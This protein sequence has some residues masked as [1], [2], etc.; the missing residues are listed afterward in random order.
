MI[1]TIQVETAEAVMSMKQGNEEVRAGI[2]LADKAGT[3][4][5]RIVKDTQETVGLINQIAAASEEQSKTSED[6]SRSVE[7]ITTV[8]EDSAR[9]MSEIARSS[10]ELNRLMNTLRGLVSQFKIGQHRP[11]RA[12]VA[13]RGAVPASDGW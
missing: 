4:L 8:T 13:P 10:D 6:I 5:N 2:S 7:S 1:Q 3:S 12:A 11:D 9:G